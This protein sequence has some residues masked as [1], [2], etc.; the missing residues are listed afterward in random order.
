M[1]TLK[2]KRVLIGVSGS[3]AAYKIAFLVRLLIKQ[4]AQVKVLMTASAK[5]F[6]P[7]VT[8]ATLSKEPVISDF[9]KNESGEWHNHVELGLWADVFVV[10][11]ASANTIAKIDRKSV[12]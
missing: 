6:I 10:A 7:P 5:A 3:I 4:G 8:L 9:Y 2:D 1:K 11:P 12:V